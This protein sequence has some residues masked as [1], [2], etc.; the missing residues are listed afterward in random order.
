[1]LSGERRLPDVAVRYGYGSGEAFARAFRAV[2]DA[3]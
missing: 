3:G 1:V 2:R